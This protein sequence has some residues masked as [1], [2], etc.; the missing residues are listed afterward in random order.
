MQTYPSADPSA[1]VGTPVLVTGT[2]SRTARISWGAIVAG[3]VIALAIGLMLNILGAAV[4]AAMVDTSTRQ[5]PVASSLGIGAAVWLLVANLIALS[6]G[7]YAAS[8]LSGTTDGT[9][10]TLHGIAVWAATLLISVVLLGNLIAGAATTAIGGASNM[11]GGLAHGAGSV[12][13]TMG[14]QVAAQ[15]PG[16]NLSAGAQSLID[17]MQGE[18]ATPTKP[19]DLSSSQRRVQIARLIRKRI[20]DGK[21]TPHDRSQ[22]D[23]LV[24]AELGVS[25]DQAK[26]KIAQAE[27]QSQA[28]IAT[29]E[30][31]ATAAAKATAH[32]TA[33]TS[34]S[35]FVTMLLG[36]LAAVLGS[37]RGTARLS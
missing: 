7:G 34:F 37:R 25:R 16:G 6:I 9:D 2:V 24:A 11:L 26:Q 5:L 33:V 36:A 35:V 10:G 31:E 18:L 32:G 28:A 27:Q 29:V 1:V 14:K 20:V 15:G 4:G 22:L 12:V 13:A 8:R 19:A 30:R 23:D 21:L 3:A 17:Q